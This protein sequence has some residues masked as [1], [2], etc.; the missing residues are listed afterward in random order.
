[1]TT[2]VQDMPGERKEFFHWA[3]VFLNIVVSLRVRPVRHYFESMK[4]GRGTDLN[5]SLVAL[6][7]QQPVKFKLSLVAYVASQ[8]I[9]THVCV[10]TTRIASQSIIKV[11]KLP[12]KVVFAFFSEI[13]FV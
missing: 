13:Y 5:Q 8:E 6:R 9:S 2:N 4:T 12:R 11:I 1:M 10:L 3:L 7:F